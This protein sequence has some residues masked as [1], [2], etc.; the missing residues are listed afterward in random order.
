MSALEVTAMRGVR[1]EIILP[2]KSNI[3]GMDYA[4]RAN[5]AKLLKKG[6][7]IYRTRP[8]FDHSK[9]VLVDKAWIFVGSA[10]W[11]VRSFKLNFECNM[12]CTDKQLAGQL[13]QIIARKKAGAFLEKWEK[14][15][16]PFWRTLR[17]NAFKLLTPYY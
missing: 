17:D 14:E 12:E 6:V 15:K 2:S 5:F 11:D 4:M 16:P 3:F 7:K 9:I 13:A 10:N 1:V 8:P